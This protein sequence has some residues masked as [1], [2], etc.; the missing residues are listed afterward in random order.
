MNGMAKAVEKASIPSIGLRTS[1][2]ADSTKMV[3][4]IGPV[5]LKEIK[6]KVNA[7]KKIPIGPP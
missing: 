1:P 6:T 2:P 5:Q 7:I 4:T 3:P